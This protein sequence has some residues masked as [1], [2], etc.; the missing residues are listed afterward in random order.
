M[1]WKHLL[2]E[3]HYV[4]KGEERQ[5]PYGHFSH[6]LRLSPRPSGWVKFNAAVGELTAEIKEEMGTTVEITL[7][8]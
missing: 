4:G 5:L 7:E 2:R 8:S 1:K 6:A 3:K